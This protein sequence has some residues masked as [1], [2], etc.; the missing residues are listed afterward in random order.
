[1]FESPTFIAERELQAQGY[2]LTAGIDEAGRGALAGPVV[3]AAV[4]LPYQANL[5]R[6]ASVRDSKQLSR[7]KREALFQVIQE[8]AIAIGVGVVPPEVIDAQ[9]I[10]EATRRAMRLAVE[11]LSFPPDFLLIDALEL[12]YLALPQKGITHGDRLCLSIACASIVAKV[13]RDR[14]MLELDNLYPEYGL[15]CHKGYATPEHLLKLRR[16]GPSPIHRTSFAPVREAR[17]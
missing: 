13:S 10:V 12:P 16:W 4:I 2:R 1:M 8:E 5:S 3:A 6:L 7:A 9:G 11:Q 15:G 14:V 17:R